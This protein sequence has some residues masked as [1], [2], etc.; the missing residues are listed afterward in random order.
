M[1]GKL[2]II[3]AGGAIP[4]MVI[5]ECR[6]Q[7]RPFAVIALEG[8]TDDALL[9]NIPDKYKKLRLGDC[10]KG[11][12]FFRK[13]EV[14]EVM[15]IGSLR[16]PSFKEIH[17]DFWALKILAKCGASIFGDDSLLSVIV[18][19]L[20]H[21]GFKVVGVHQVLPEILSKEGVYGKYKPDND[22]LVDIKRGFEVA[23]GIGG[24]DIGQSVI[25]QQGMVIGVEAIE[26]TDALIKRCKDLQRK[27]KKGVLVKV[28]KPAQEERIDLPTVGIETVKNAF[29][30][31]LR[32]IAIEAGA[33]LVVDTPNVIKELDKNKMFMIGI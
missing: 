11:I 19:A 16:R 8:I 7:N 1:Q 2:G 33:T 10:A 31:G 22:A 25:V 4:S 26:G 14:K 24:L 29:A 13:E 5:E 28:K 6:K 18:K 23:K 27:G 32:G 12:D 20:E 3:A 15:F 30:S 17:L 9:V 21:E